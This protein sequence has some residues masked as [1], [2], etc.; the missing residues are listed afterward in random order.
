MAAVFLHGFSHGSN[1]RQQKSTPKNEEGNKQHR[2]CGLGI[3]FTQ[4]QPLLYFSSKY[5]I[6]IYSTAYTWGRLSGRKARN[7]KT[8]RLKTRRKLSKIYLKVES[9][10]GFVVLT[11]SSCA[12]WWKSYR[13]C[14]LYFLNHE[15]RTGALQ[16]HQHC[17]KKCSKDLE[18]QI[19]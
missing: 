4:Q 18:V 11:S 17:K 12:L 16:L 3:F 5:R 9:R 19:L 13:H 8:E 10:N 6:I 14:T 2:G 7:A 1:L 15:T